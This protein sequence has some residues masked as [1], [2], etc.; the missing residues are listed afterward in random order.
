MIELPGDRK[1]QRSID[2]QGSANPAPHVAPC[3]SAEEESI[4]TSDVAESVADGQDEEA[5]HEGFFLGLVYEG[6]D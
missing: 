5:V 4:G 3:L 6:R 2:S 1:R